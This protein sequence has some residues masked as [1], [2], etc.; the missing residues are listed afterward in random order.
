MQRLVDER[1]IAPFTLNP[2]GITHPAGGVVPP[3]PM[4]I[5]E[6]KEPAENL[7][8]GQVNA[9]LHDEMVMRVGIPHK[10]GHMAAHAFN[11]AYPV[12]VSTN[13]FW[14]QSKQAFAFPEATDLSETDF[15]MDSAGFVA[16]KLWKAKGRQRGMGGIFPW[17]YA[18]YIEFATGS[19]ASWWSQSDCCVEPE[20]ATSEDEVDFRIRATGTFLEGTLR[21]L[22]EWQ[23][24]LAKTTT[25]NVVAN[26]LPPPVPVIQ[27]W[28]AEH[29][30]RSMEMMMQVWQRWQPWL[31]APALIGVGSVCRRPLRHPRHG[32]YAI[33]DRVKTM[34]PTGS[35]FHLFGVKGEAL[36]ELGDQKWIAS[37]DSM[38]Y[39]FGA[40]L[41]AHRT[42]VSNSMA[43][44]CTEMDRWMKA[45]MQRISAKNEE[46]YSP[47]L[48]A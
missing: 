47:S 36:R 2:T 46:R 33:L 48:V 24:E 10:S 22:Y 9:H 45:A 34:I 25:S 27:G 19:G 4:E 17:T 31:A 13:A 37:A 14:S 11:Q 29:Y 44:R 16:M 18:E 26:L 8:F 23:N 21:I 35:R 3:F 20:I 15:A 38:A 30:E 6:M 43:H 1:V 41:K 32:L 12:M 28:E 7:P 5:H 42:G 39:D 40:R